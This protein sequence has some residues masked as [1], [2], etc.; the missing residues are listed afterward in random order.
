MNTDEDT[1]IVVE[2]RFFLSTHLSKPCRIVASSK[3]LSIYSLEKNILLERIAIS[4][5]YGCLCMRPKQPSPKSHLVIFVYGRKGKNSK[6]SQSQR[7]FTYA[8][9]E[10]Y[11]KNFSEVVRWHQHLTNAIYL[12][13][14][15]PSSS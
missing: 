12:H 4:Y 3:F 15:L 8:N 5:I 13:R 2:D 14:N 1:P 7:I 10:R 9:H 6:F 11:E